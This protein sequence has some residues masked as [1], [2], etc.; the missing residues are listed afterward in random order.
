MAGVHLLDKLIG[1]EFP[2]F[3]GPA[4]VEAFEATP[5]ADRIA[6]SNT[7]EALK[8]GTSFDPQLPALHFL[9]EGT[10]EETPETLTHGQFFAR[11]T[12]TANLLHDLG[13]GPRDTVS[14]LLPLIPQNYFA[15]F[16][17]EAAG[18]VNPVNSF[19]EPGQI[20]DILKAA[21]TRVLIALGPAS[22][23]DIW[24]K[25]Q[26]IRGE[27]PN[28]KAIL[29][30]AGPG[31][32]ADGVLP[33][34]SL[35]ENQPGDRLVSGREIAADEIAAFFHTGG[36]T[37]LP[38][39]VRHTHGNQVYQ[40]WAMNLML[41]ARAGVSLLCG[42]PLFHVGGSLTQLLAPVCAAQNVV[43]LTPAGFRNPAVIR[44]FWGLVERYRP[45]VIGA[46]PTVF[47]AVLSTPFEGLDLSSLEYVS[48]GGS[49]IPVEVGK[50]L[51]ELTGTPVLEVYGMTE[52]SSVH[53]IA[54]AHRDV[55]LGSVGHAVP[56]SRVRTVEL[57]GEGAYRR[58]CG[59]DEIGVV[60]MQG[61]GVFQGYLSESH[62][63]SAF[64]EPGWVNSG[65]LGRLDG[66]G[67]L[68]I[69][70]RA[71]D[72]I[73]RGGHNID[74]LPV[75]EILYGHPG[76]ELAAL[77]G[78]PDAYAGEMP[79]AYVQPK[80]GVA[81]DADEL[82]AL[83]R[84]RTPERAAVPGEVIL[85]DPLPLTP[86]GKVFKPALRWDSARRVF[87]TILAP[88]AESGLEAEVQVNAHPLHGTLATV[89][90]SGVDGGGREA[91]E[92]QVHELLDPFTIRHEIVWG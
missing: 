20:A 5:Y 88:L 74:P 35:L 15:V 3:R 37:G 75:E 45:A 26:A 46:V 53:T 30:V 43:V 36:T 24:E 82:L 48:G 12:Q 18:I 86:V 92:E 7:Y 40:A 23:S 61:P 89:T 84:K 41:R 68:W 1:S 78:R 57:D 63:R 31:D 21:E 6:A 51:Q 54:Y 64:V 65:D 55:R 34:D 42:L 69:T 17:A 66:E 44:N 49:A 90:L 25:V 71:K 81:V 83:I 33:F 47:S 70:G 38:K 80:P 56:Y 22:G 60:T 58:D 62:N 28:L 87:S 52:T 29:Q 2:E 9:R 16:G 72:I 85:L 39:L 32:E 79:V 73:I 14:I 19:L 91:A 8:I 10:P 27:L 4:D 76:V 11:V 50:A 13:V 59:P 67:Y 77:V